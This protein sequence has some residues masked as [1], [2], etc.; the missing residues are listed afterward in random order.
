MA[1]DS[2]PAGPIWGRAGREG[3]SHETERVGACEAICG[4]PE[5]LPWKPPQQAPGTHSTHHVPPR[6]GTAKASLR[7]GISGGNF[8]V[9]CLH[10]RTVAGY[11]R[12][13]SKEALSH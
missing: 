13:P 12:S 4:C 7:A 2:P 11:Q 10:R 8:L 6:D 3:R 9:L 5:P 1:E